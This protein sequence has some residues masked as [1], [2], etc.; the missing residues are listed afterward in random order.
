MVVGRN[1]NPTPRFYDYEIMRLIPNMKKYPKRMAKLLSMT[2][3]DENGRT[4][5]K[6]NYADINC[7]I[8]SP[9]LYKEALEGKR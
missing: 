6:Y 7:Y 2:K 5:P 1:G 9:R 4:V 8:D 3:V